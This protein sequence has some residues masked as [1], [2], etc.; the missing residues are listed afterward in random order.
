[1]AEG[2]RADA[3]RNPILLVE[4]AGRGE[5]PPCEDAVF[6]P[7]DVVRVRDRKALAKIPRELVVFVAVPPGFPAEH[8]LAD[9]LDEPRPLMITKPFACISYILGR[10]GDKRP[11]HLLESDLLPT[12]KPPVQIGTI[13]REVYSVPQKC[14]VC[15]C[16]ENNAC[17][18]EAGACSWVEPD[19]CSACHDVSRQDHQ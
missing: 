3:N 16:T 11:Y 8:A 5:T 9:L 13:R 14:R 19:L 2:G 1:M 7:G 12:D 4:N 18:T 17:L 10:E 15:G 6:K